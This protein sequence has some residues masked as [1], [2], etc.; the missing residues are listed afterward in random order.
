MPKQPKK[1]D[2]KKA[3][4]ELYRARKSVEELDA[5]RGTFLTCDGQGAPGAELYQEA[6]GRLYSLAYTTKFMLKGAGVLDFGIPNLECLWFSDPTGTPMSE[7]EWRLQL[8]LPEQ[9]TSE[10]LREAKKALKER[11]GAD[12][13]GVRLR[14]WTEGRAV[15]VLHVGPYD[16][17]DRSYRALAEYAEAHGLKL[18]S[19]GHEVYLSDPR[20]VPPD[21]LKTIVRMP[22]A[23]GCR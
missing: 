6:I 2:L 14:Q 12:L 20:R 23:R 13:R 17:V 11:K 16:A 8:R 7:W 4:P 19:P 10:H 21:R 1:I 18:K 9:V 5:G 3:H 22:V 15:Q